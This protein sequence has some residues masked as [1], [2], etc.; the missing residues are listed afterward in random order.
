MVRTTTIIA[1]AALLGAINVN[2]AAAQASKAVCKPAGSLMTLAALPEASGAAIGNSSATRLWMHND[3][4]APELIAVDQAGK[5]A[6]RVTVSGARVDDWEAIA[7]G[8]CGKGSCLYVGDIGDNNASRK[9]ITIYRLEQPSQSSGSVKADAFHAMYPDGAHDAETLLASRD[10]TLFVVTKGDT[11]P[12]AVYRFPR[13]LQAGKVMTLER[14]GQPIAEKPR[15]DGRIT[16]GAFS[17][18]GRWV[19]LRSHRALTFY[20]GDTFINGDFREAHRVDV[21][22]LNEPQ[23]EAVV[24]G[25]GNTVFVAGEGG[26]KKQPGTLAA[27]TCA[28]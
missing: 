24:F 20:R 12:V 1:A 10:G 25:A 18:D 4:G 13:E 6:G 27:L 5:V 11:G 22:T 19:V 28:L 26:G 17:A 2:G 15:D 7:S 3:S 14:V 9:Q 21:S 16:D 8:P 23:G